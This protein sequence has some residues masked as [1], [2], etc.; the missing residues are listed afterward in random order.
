MVE[1][2]R[3]VFPEMGSRRFQPRRVSLAAL[4]FWL[5]IF[6]SSPTCLG[7]DFLPGVER[8]VI[9]AEEKNLARREAEM[10]DEFVLLGTEL[11]LGGSDWP[12]FERNHT[13]DLIRSFTPPLLRP[14]FVG[15]AFVLPPKSG[16]DGGVRPRLREMISLPWANPIW[17]TS[18]I[19]AS[20][21]N[22]WISTCFMDLIWAK[23][24]C[25]IFRSA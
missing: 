5:A 13:K 19:S 24:G 16:S 21:A 1:N 10:T 6:C 2:G 4:A 18:R 9:A 3:P 14:A 7:Q 15:H 11:G 25:T 22:S 12:E 17:Q 8:D 20:T 23:S